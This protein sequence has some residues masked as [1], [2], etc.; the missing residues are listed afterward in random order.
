MEEIIIG[1]DFGTTNTSIA[2]MKYNNDWT[3]FTPECFDLDRGEVIRSAITYR[4]EE[5]FWIGKDA[6][7]YSYDYPMGFIDSLKR[8]VINNTLRDKAFGNKTELDIMSDF[9]SW[10]IKEIEPQI[11]Y[12]TKVGGVAIGIPIGFKD[13]HKEFYLRSMVEAGIYDD[14]KTAYEKTIFVSEPI[15]AVLNYNVSLKDDK[16][17]LV[18][19]FGGGTL[20]LVIM[21]MKNVRKENEIS[22]HD[23]IAKKGYLDLGG[24][25]FDKAILENIIVE[26]YGMRNLKRALGI[27]RLEDI[28][29]VQE[30][31]ELMN[32]IR[33]AKEELSRYNLGRINFSK[34]KLKM[35]L[36]I[37]RSEYEAAISSYIDDI[38]ALVQDCILE[39]GLNYNEIDLVVLSGGSSLTPIVQEVI[40][41][42]FGND[43]V[44]VDGNAMT[45]IARGLALR[46]HDPQVNKYNDIL[47][48]DYGVRMKDE[49][50]EDSI[51]EIVLDK[52]KKIKDIN[53][54]EYYKE[55]ELMRRAKGKNAFKVTICENDEVIGDAY[56][57]LSEEMANSKFKLY[58]T[59]DE[60]NERLELHIYDSK[61]DKKVEVPMEYRY[62]QIKK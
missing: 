58:F 21:D 53:E 31:I 57:P 14:Y 22:P 23:V 61:W 25:D 40:R 37:T 32:E 28:L 17:V 10:V 60:N 33:E 9:L 24:N 56:I 44:K 49:F 34:G 50:G 48:H 29:T 47:E 42:I 2:F 35:N 13:R 6:L 27:N 62:I 41:D 39:S 51:I 19:D 11:P 18:F 15:A 38:K 5:I 1:M 7:N 20:D 55:F 4:D 8:Q 30:G 3:S 36:E 46:G 45:C 52:G 54:K 26:K 16:K 12:G 59:I 43:K